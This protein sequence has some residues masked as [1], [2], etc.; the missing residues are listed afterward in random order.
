MPPGGHNRTRKP[1]AERF[2]AK[3]LR[4][5]DAECWIWTG[6]KTADGYGKIMTASAK[7][8]GRHLTET[9]GAHR[10]SYFLHTGVWP[11]GDTRH[12]CHNPSCVNPAHLLPGTR[13]EN[14]RD[15]VD[16]GRSLVGELQPMHKLTWEIVREAR[17]RNIECGVAASQLARDY[18]V[19]QRTMAQCLSGETWKEPPEG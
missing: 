16:A 19:D 9:V 8:D 4:A 6:T 13:G 3:V 17:R 18:A 1:L 5:G 15:M 14:M 10:L 12:L 7:V 2:W 11:P